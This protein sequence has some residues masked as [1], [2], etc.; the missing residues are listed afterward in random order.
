MKDDSTISEQDLRKLQERIWTVEKERDSALR[1]V[2]SLQEKGADVEGL[3]E[4]NKKLSRLFKLSPSFIFI[5]E[6]ETGIFL[7]VNEAYCELTGYSSHELIGRSSLELGIVCPE[8]RKR[9]AQQ[10]IK[11]EFG[12]LT[13]HILSKEGKVK[14][15][16]FSSEIIEIDGKPCLI[17]SGIELTSPEQVQQE[18]AEKKAK[19]RDLQDENKI[20][21]EK[22]KAVV[23]QMT[24]GLV[25]FDPEGNL[26]DMNPAALKIHGFD[27]ITALQRHL[28]TLTDTFKLFDLQNNPLSTDQWPIGKVLKGEQ[29]SS[30]VVK[31]RRCDTGK[32][33]IGS[34]GGTPIYDQSGNM[35]LA[36]VTLRD[37]SERKK[38]EQ[39]L[40]ESEE[41]FRTMAD[42]LPLIVWVHDAYGEQQFVNRTFC[43][44]FG[45]KL[46][47]MKGPNW[48]VLMHPDDADAY[49][50]EFLE[51]VRNQQPFHGEVQVKRADGDWRW[52]ESWARPLFSPSGEFLGMIGTSADITD[53]K[54]AEEGLKEAKAVAEKASHVKSEFLAIMS[55]EIRTPM[56]TFMLALQH[57]QNLH[58]EPEHQRLLEMASKSAVHLRTL[59]DD[60][61]D[62]SQIEARQVKT[63]NEPINLKRCVENSVDLLSLS[64]QQKN[65]DLDIDFGL[66]VPAM[67]VSDDDRLSQVLVNLV[68][69]AVKFTDQGKVEVR[70][71]SENSRL[72]FAVTDT[73]PGIPPEKQDLLFNHF[74]QVDGSHTRKKGGTGL[75]LAICKG[76][77]ELMGGEIGVESRPGEGSTFWF[78][79]PLEIP[80]D[81]AKIAMK[82][83][84]PAKSPVQDEGLRILLAE[85]D[86][87]IRQLMNIIFKKWRCQVKMVTNGLQA[88]EAFRP[89]KFD[90]VFLDM[91][92]PEMGGLE[93]THEIRCMER[94]AGKPPVKIIALTADVQCETQQ[95]CKEA[96][97]DSF[98]SKPLE[99]DSLY[100][101]L[102]Q[103]R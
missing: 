37:V 31:V 48:K 15:V 42:G 60:I 35:S 24:E 59:I 80:D 43:E 57:L 94:E 95:Q 16:I 88:V 97:M 74:S 63:K 12:R 36:I 75:G 77:L 68:G 81:H 9:I 103:Q 100:A 38:L 4:C 102:Q 89:G 55:H 40:K 99:I 23:N 2:E 46:E 50:T 17:T 78:T 76:L 39:A 66:A 92:M 73:G 90:L 11:G 51:S 79:L 54:W 69:N 84:S 14:E 18:L 86:A 27:D 56:T 82:Q 20:T 21:S 28:E 85:D 41:R 53:R 26:L 13:A 32:T 8:D 3:S 1:K 98:L 45:V 71:Q 65:I 67:V 87:M 33:W 19:F 72:H 22:L 101:I 49:S 47:E 83:K 64:A 10:I 44:F 62:F 96:G 61:L 5:S 30:Y 91:H 25:I 93:A 34:Y 7:E 58:Q 29:F 52:I 6:L 70:V